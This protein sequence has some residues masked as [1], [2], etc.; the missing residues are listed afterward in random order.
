MLL[1]CKRLYDDQG[2][3]HPLPA[4]VRDTVNAALKR[5]NNGTPLWVRLGAAY[6][7]GYTHDIA[8]DFKRPSQLLLHMECARGYNLL[9]LAQ[10]LIA[11]GQEEAGAL[12]R[13]AILGKQTAPTPRQF[14]HAP[15]PQQANPAPVPQRVVPTPP[16][17][18]ARQAAPARVPQQAAPAPQPH[19]VSITRLCDPG[20]PYPLP[21]KLRV[22]MGKVVQR[23]HPGEHRD[24]WIS[25]GVKRIPRFVYTDYGRD[26]PWWNMLLCLERQ[27]DYTLLDLADDLFNGGQ[28]EPARMLR[29]AI[30]ESPDFE[31]P[32]AQVGHP[33]QGR[34][35]V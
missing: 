5:E 1:E 23:S 33:D 31:P 30:Q 18:A 35:D 13:E 25:I 14:A 27:T 16:T 8:Q 34:E 26:E 4:P 32:L 2:H 7:Y 19:I 17:Q 6:G 11:R 10:D 29:K 12:L 9:Q 21:D 15:G 24:L 20:H 28:Q 22:Q 3:S